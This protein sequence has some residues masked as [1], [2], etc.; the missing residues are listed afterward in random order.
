MCIPI[1]YILCVKILRMYRVKKKQLH[2]DGN[3]LFSHRD[4]LTGQQLCILTSWSTEKGC[5]IRFSVNLSRVS[6]TLCQS[7]RRLCAFDRSESGADLGHAVSQ[8]N[9]AHSANSW[10]LSRNVSQL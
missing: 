7:Q 8:G 9:T 3:L 5:L 4:G 1:I 6:P 2:V 10:K